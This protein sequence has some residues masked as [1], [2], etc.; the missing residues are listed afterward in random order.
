MAIRSGTK[1]RARYK[2]PSGVMVKFNNAITCS[3]NLATNFRTIIHK[4]NP[5]GH[6]ES[7]PDGRN[8]TITVN[9]FEENAGTFKDL[10]EAR[11]ADELLTLE[12]T[13]SVATNDL[14]T[15]TGY[16]QNIQRTATVRE[17]VSANMTFLLVSD[18]VITAIP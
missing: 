6:D 4:D 14:Y 2:R 3:E 7:I 18:P 5:G 17:S 15:Y 16:V 11:L 12:V 1:L 10:M 9:F 13:D 8:G